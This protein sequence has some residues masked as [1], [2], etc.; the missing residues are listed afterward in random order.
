MYIN[1]LT[2]YPNVELCANQTVVVVTMNSV[3]MPKVV[4]AGLPGYIS[5]FAWTWYPVFP[6]FQMVSFSDKIEYGTSDNFIASGGPLG[7]PIRT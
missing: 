1:K 7:A 6:A 4:A 5:P 3:K 2:I